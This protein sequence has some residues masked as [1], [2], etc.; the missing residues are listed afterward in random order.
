MYTD[1][2]LSRGRRRLLHR[3]LTAIDEM[4]Y[5]MRAVLRM[6][7][8]HAILCTANRGQTTTRL[9]PLPRMSEFRY[10]EMPSEYTVDGTGVWPEICVSEPFQCQSDSLQIPPSISFLQFSARHSEEPCVYHHQVAIT[11]SCPSKSNVSVTHFSFN[12]VGTGTI[13]LRYGHIEFHL[14]LGP[15][16]QRAVWLERDSDS[17]RLSGRLVKMAPSKNGGYELSDLCTPQGLP[18]TTSEIQ[19]M[20][21]DEVYT[22]VAICLINGSMWFLDFSPTDL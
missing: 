5:I 14:C 20:A 11:K 1:G 12:P 9:Y 2:T 19:C 15:S 6:T 8:Q 16:G 7:E 18:F 17:E 21:F 22:R 10:K 4:Q 13:P 3:H